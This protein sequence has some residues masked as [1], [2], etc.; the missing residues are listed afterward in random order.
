MVNYAYGP[1]E[2]LGAVH[3]MDVGFRFGKPLGREVQRRALLET[4]QSAWE[5]GQTAHAADLL[6]EIN[7]FSPHYY[8][9]EVLGKEVN[10]RIEESLKPDTLYNLG[11]RAYE[12]KDFEAAGDY[13]RKLVMLDP[14]Y[15]E[16]SILLKKAESTLSKG[17]ESR[18][19]EELAHGLE[20]QRRALSRT[21]QKAQ[22]RGRWSEALKSWR[23]ILVRFPKDAEA[24]AKVIQC[25]REMVALAKSAEKEGAIE[26]A[27]FHYRALQEDR[28]DPAVS[29]RIEKLT[30]EATR[31]AETRARELYQEGVRVYDAGD[32]K[33]ALPLFE[34]SVRLNPND[35]AAA[36]ARDRV[37]TETKRGTEERKAR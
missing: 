23:Y 20:R 16:A 37:R 15:P 11:L 1:N 31:K 21:A 5:K 8:P 4:A 35:E 9:A 17:R 7:E 12:E 32:L 18:A 19:R 29:Q 25:R 27:V 13:L 14:S 22:E 33:K 28:F 3:R 10:R 6:E 24:L 34:E 26:M 2:N 36:R 30:R